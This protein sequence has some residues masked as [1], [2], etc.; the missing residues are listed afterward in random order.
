[1]SKLCLYN[2]LMSTI[3]SGKRDPI[4]CDNADLI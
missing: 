4:N 2:L 3:P 1:M